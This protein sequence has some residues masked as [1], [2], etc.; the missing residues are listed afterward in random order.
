MSS[1]K[2]DA[3]SLRVV[4]SRIDKEW[5]EMNHEERMAFLRG[6]VS[7]CESEDDLAE[8]LSEIGIGQ[9][10]IR[11][12]DLPP[13]DA[14]EKGVRGDARDASFLVSGNDALVRIITH[15]ERF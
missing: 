13:N 6:V 14:T 1:D 12:E 9:C 8:C 10:E 11:W 5:S 4:V 7:R 15:D 3:E 2:A